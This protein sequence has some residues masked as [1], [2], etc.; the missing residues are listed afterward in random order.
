VRKFFEACFSHFCDVG[1][2]SFKRHATEEVFH[3]AGVA[4]LDEG[5]LYGGDVSIS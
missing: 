4:V 3:E 2:L 1:F 5:F